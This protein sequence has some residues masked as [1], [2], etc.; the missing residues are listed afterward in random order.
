MADTVSTY[1]TL[2]L[3][4]NQTSETRNYKIT[5]V[6]ESIASVLKTN[7]QNYNQNI[8]EK[9]RSIFI[10]DDYDS[11]QGIGTLNKITGAKFVKVTETPIEEASS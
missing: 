7:V 1:I 10:S 5:D 6:Q 11:S 8:T 2:T 4:Y 3:G 9:D